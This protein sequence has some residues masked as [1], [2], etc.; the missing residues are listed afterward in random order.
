MEEFVSVQVHQV[1]GLMEPAIFKE[2]CLEI[3][4]RVFE[5]GISEMKDKLWSKAEE[6]LEWEDDE[7]QGISMATA[8][9]L[10]SAYNRR[11][12][13]LNATEKILLA[14]ITSLT[15][16]QVSVWFQNRRQR[17]HPPTRVRGGGQAADWDPLP[18]RK[19]DARAAR[20]SS[21]TRYPHLSSV[22]GSYG[23]STDKSAEQPKFTRKRSGLHIDSDDDQFV[24]RLHK[25]SRISAQRVSTPGDATDLPTGRP[26]LTLIGEHGEA[27]QRRTLSSTGG[28]R[29]PNSAA[30][31][32]TL[33][34]GTDAA[35]QRMGSIF[36]DWSFDSDATLVED[37]MTDAATEES[38]SSP[39]PNAPGSSDDEA[40]ET[41]PSTSDYAGEQLGS[42]FWHYLRGDDGN[43][44]PALL[45]AVH[46]LDPPGFSREAFNQQL[47][48]AFGDAFAD[49]RSEDFDQILARY[50]ADEDPAT[51]TQLPSSSQP[52]VVG[53]TAT[54]QDPGFDADTAFY[55]SLFG[56][57]VTSM[58]S[59]GT[60]TV[61][62]S[63][64]GAHVQ[65]SHHVL[66]DASGFDPIPDIRLVQA[67]TPRMSLQI[68]S[69]PLPLHRDARHQYDALQQP[70]TLIPPSSRI[71]EAQMALSSA[72]EG[73]AS[74]ANLVNSKGAS[75]EA[76]PSV[77]GD[78]AIA[79]P[80]RLPSSSPTV[81]QRTPEARLSAAS[82]SV[83]SGIEGTGADCLATTPGIGAT[84]LS[85]ISSSTTESTSLSTSATRE[86][87][88][89]SVMSTA[90]RRSSI[91]AVIS[92]ALSVASYIPGWL[93]GLM[94]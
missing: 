61:I 87:P 2:R 72:V 25:R 44:P 39:V 34:N 77:N 31:G 23:R 93:R 33:E 52:V 54:E 71:S 5:R 48:A 57:S 59:D 67:T 85:Q 13:R 56:T 76:L 78:I 91:P 10:E 20:R 26:L 14:R 43:E 17:G 18:Q 84:P 41:T 82:L 11:Q 45:G 3:Y 36:S 32:F 8:R 68:M 12:G 94:N 53:P 35:R 46:L 79:R 69:N 37:L 6:W 83:P 28:S 70:S 1:S 15:E 7:T 47:D 16:R 24:K 80:L 19:D 51:S 40:E 92:S 4:R 58:T 88:T 22:L 90:P 29:S 74:L 65:T 63:N 27:Q 81:I 9:I 55:N 21:P 30:G 62:G 89:S 42:D 64:E 66:G 75:H 50:M 60:M 38:D 73:A 49:V 86:N